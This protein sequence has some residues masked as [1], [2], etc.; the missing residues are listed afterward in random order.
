MVEIGVARDQYLSNGYGLIVEEVLFIFGE[1][2]NMQVS[3]LNYGDVTVRFQEI[4]MTLET[5]QSISE[6]VTTI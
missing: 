1:R 4:R 5:L 3:V 6:K 2:P